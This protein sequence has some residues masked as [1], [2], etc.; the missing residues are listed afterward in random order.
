MARYNTVAAVSVQNGATTFSS[1][2]Q[3][4]FTTLT[5][6]T[7]FTVTLTQPSQASG[8]TQGFYNNAGG[9]VTLAVPTPGSQRI[10]GP[11]ANTATTF[12]M[13][14]QS[15]VFLTSDGTNYVL[16]GAVTGG[17]VNVDVTGTYTAAASQL[18]WVNTTSTAL[19]VTLPVAPARGDTIR[20]IDV[21][22]TFNTNTLTVNRN[23]QPINGD[24]SGNLTVTTQGAAFDL[25]YYDATRGWRIF[26]I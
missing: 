16:T 10:L 5:G 18:L 3:G 14:N 20:I 4:L 9:P 24:V 8:V 11:A 15:V 21:A 26:T 22:N 12:I 23:G 17:F 25:I 6:T 2:T 19:T 7:P 13:Q 1:P